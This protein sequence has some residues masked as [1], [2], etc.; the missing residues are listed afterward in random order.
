[1]LANPDQESAC[2]CGSGNPYSACCHR[3][4]TG[5]E[6]PTSAESLM[7]S[8]YTAYALHNESY[9]L[10]TWETTKR[11]EKINFSTENWTKLEII[12]ITKGSDKDSL[13]SVEFKAYYLLEN[14]QYVMNEIS[15]FEKIEGKWLYLDGLLKSAGKVRQ[16]QIQS[17]NAPCCC[18]SGK[19][20]KR[21]CG[22]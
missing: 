20:F 14:E 15:R 12:N 19:K 13:G 17:K 22:K 1:M 4:H 6:F 21:C 9:L 5:N 3:F 7:R 10:T 16:L 11:P 2:L 8:R 18:G